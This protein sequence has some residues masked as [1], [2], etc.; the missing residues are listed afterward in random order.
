MIIF[1]NPSA[2]ALVLSLAALYSIVDDVSNMRT[3]TMTEMDDFRVRT[4]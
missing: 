4:L 2:V 1:C 3:E